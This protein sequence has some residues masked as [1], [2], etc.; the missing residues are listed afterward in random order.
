MLQLCFAIKF[1]K[2]QTFPNKPLHYSN[3]KKLQIDQTDENHYLEGSSSTGV[4]PLFKAQA[5]AI[6][7]YVEQEAFPV[8]DAYATGGEVV[9][10]DAVD[11]ST[12]DGV[13]GN[14]DSSD[15]SDTVNG[16][17]DTLKDI[18]GQIKDGYNNVK[19]GVKDLWGSLTGN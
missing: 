1:S 17:G 3:T 13:G 2:C 18:G 10:A 16:I 4:G 14:G 12:P 15:W 8:A 9:A 5:E 7:P 11:T 6:L 19:D